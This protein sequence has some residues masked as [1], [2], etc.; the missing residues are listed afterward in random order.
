MTEP[1]Q[2]ERDELFIKQLGTLVAAEA[3]LKAMC[4]S[5]GGLG[6]EIWGDD[7]SYAFDQVKGARARIIQRI[8]PTSVMRSGFALGASVHVIRAAAEQQAKWYIA[9]RGEMLS[10]KGDGDGG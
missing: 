8:D 1:T 4:G 7:V 2:G 9:I 6:I 5:L 3:M 10:S